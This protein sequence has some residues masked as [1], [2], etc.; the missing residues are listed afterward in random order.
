MELGAQD[1][2]SS[3]EILLS[4]GELRAWYRPSA[5]CEAYRYEKP[6]G[7]TICQ[8]VPFPIKTIHILRHAKGLF[9]CRVGLH[10]AENIGF[11]IL[12]IGEPANTGYSHFWKHDRAAVLGNG[13]SNRIDRLHVD[14]AYISNHRGTIDDPSSTNQS[15]VNARLV[16]GPRLNQ[17][18]LL[19]PGP[20]R[21]RPIEQRLVEPNRSIR[22][23]GVKLEMDYPRHSLQLCRRTAP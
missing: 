15:P 20:L 21:E 18:I 11:R 6:H 7:H 2:L 8:S 3:R 10:H 12:R 5:D 23:L 22:F 4:I 1:R 9:R 13:F 14:S 19:R 17:P 16:V